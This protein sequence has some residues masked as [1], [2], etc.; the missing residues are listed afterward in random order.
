MKLVSYE[1]D[2]QRAIG[3]V[4]DDHVIRISG[5]GLPADMTQFLEMGDQAQVRA[6]EIVSGGSADAV[7]LSQVKFLAP[8]PHPP[9]LMMGG[10]NYLRHI[11]ELQQ[12]DETIPVPPTPRIFAKY[13]IAITGPG[14]PVIY[15]KMVKQLDF[16]GEFSVVI[17][18]S[19]RYISESEAMDHVFGYTIVNDVTARDIQ[20]T[21][22]LI[23]SK[24]FETFAPMGPWIVTRDE[25]ID[26]HDLLVRTYINDRQVSESHTSEM[27]F[28]IPQYISFLSQVFPLEVGDVLT[29]GSPPG[30]GM[31]HDPPILT[32]VGDVMRI[33]VEGIGTLEN[34]V[35]AAT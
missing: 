24:S 25:D 18:R 12:Q 2:G 8:V 22:E 33:E 16:E 11:G 30:P 28:N 3:A 10:R 20:A 27:I 17:G 7:P 13:N 31:Y 26:P 35:V 34:P 4:A 29:T 5:S 23:V 19:G 32:E 15:P 9:K 1:M 21:G 14:H 6:R